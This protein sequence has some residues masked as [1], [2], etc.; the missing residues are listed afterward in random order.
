MGTLIGINWPWTSVPMWAYDQEVIEQALHMVLFTAVGEMKMN[1]IFGSQLREIVFENKGR[2]L[3]GLAR[4]EIVLAISQ[5]LP[6][7]EIQN[8]DIVE[9]EDDNDPVTIFVHYRYNEITGVI[10]EEF[11][12]AGA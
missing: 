11:L 1:D 7:V 2:I 12:R 4:R 5:N 9:P 10:N 3:Q 8:V 6:F